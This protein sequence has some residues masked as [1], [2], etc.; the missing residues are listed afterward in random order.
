MSNANCPKAVESVPVVFDVNAPCPKAVFDAILE[1]PL[2]VTST[3]DTS[4]GKE[5]PRPSLNNFNVAFIDELS[6]TLI[7]ELYV[8]AGVVPNKVAIYIYYINSK[9]LLL[10]AIVVLSIAIAEKQNV[11]MIHGL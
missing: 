5:F 6:P 2:F 3:V 7:N 11:L 10:F 9:L 1:P 8:A 4:N